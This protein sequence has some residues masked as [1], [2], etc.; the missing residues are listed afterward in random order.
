M[1]N[2]TIQMKVFVQENLVIY[3]TGKIKIRKTEIKYE[4]RNVREHVQVEYYRY[5]TSSRACNVIS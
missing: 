1:E 5:G 4:V 3:F 2:S